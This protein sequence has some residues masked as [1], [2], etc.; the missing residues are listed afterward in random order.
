MMLHAILIVSAAQLHLV[1]LKSA[2][3][4]RTLKHVDHLVGAEEDSPRLADLH[5]WGTGIIQ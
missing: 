4:E 5:V 1:M 3:D 2:S